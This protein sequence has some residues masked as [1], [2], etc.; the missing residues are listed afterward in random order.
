[1]GKPITEYWPSFYEGIKDFIELAQTED[2]E[3]Q[4]SRQAIDQ[5]FDDQFVMTSGNDAIK[6]R[7]KM[8]GIQADPT[9][10]TLDFRRKRIINRYSTKPPFTIRYLQELMD[11]LVGPG[12]TIVSVDV[13]QFILTVTANIE[14]ANVF[15]EVIR[16]VETVKPT[17]LTYQQNTSLHNTIELEAYISKQAI[18]WNYSLG[19]W[20]LGENPFSTLGPEV[21]I[22]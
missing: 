20:A 12:M 14:N 22:T 21:R 10:E 16:T 11:R 17:N 5:L 3:L 18:T 13:Q 1:M 19:S 7:E 6:R 15:K 8:L 4:L 2:A 9:R